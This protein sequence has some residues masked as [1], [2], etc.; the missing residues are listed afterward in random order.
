[1]FRASSSLHDTL[2][3]KLIRFI[4]KFMLYKPH[5]I[6]YISLY[7]EHWTLRSGTYKIYKTN[8]FNCTGQPMQWLDDCQRNS[9]RFHFTGDQIYYNKWS[10]AVIN[11]CLILLSWVL[12]GDFSQFNFF[13]FNQHWIFQCALYSVSHCTTTTNRRHHSVWLWCHVCFETPVHDFRF[14]ACFQPK[15]RKTYVS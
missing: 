7:N 14:P 12:D 2:F 4:K 11:Y 3:G 15:P 5:G 9:Q 6:V 8:T 1:M 10:H 13:T